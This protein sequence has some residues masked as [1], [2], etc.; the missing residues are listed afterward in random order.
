MRKISSICFTYWSSAI[1]RCKQHKSEKVPHKYNS[2]I[3]LKCITNICIA[4][5]PSL[6]IHN[7]ALEQALSIQYQ[8]G[9]SMWQYSRGMMEL[10]NRWQQMVPLICLWACAQCPH[11]IEDVPGSC[12]ASEHNPDQS[13]GCRQAPRIVKTVRAVC[14]LALAALIT[15]KP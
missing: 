14:A 3:V 11:V 5:R 12:T 10:E 2:K 7:C 15:F 13:Y 4:M 8:E 9:H 6:P 1:R